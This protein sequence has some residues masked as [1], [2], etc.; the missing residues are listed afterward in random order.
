MQ[1]WTWNWKTIHSPYHIF[2]EPLKFLHNFAIASTN[3]VSRWTVFFFWLRLCAGSSSN[4]RLTKGA[5]ECEC[6][7]DYVSLIGVIRRVCFKLEHCS[8]DKAD[9]AYFSIK[10]AALQVKVEP[11]RYSAQTMCLVHRSIVTPS[12]LNPRSDHMLRKKWMMS[13][14][15]R[16]WARKRAA[17]RSKTFEGE[18]AKIVI[19]IHLYLNQNW[20]FVMHTCDVVYH[21]IGV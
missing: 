20:G 15:N 3:M 4:G 10:C 16:F 5:E 18:I 2:L 12:D 9:R 13:S 17:Q 8:V 14:T 21:C 7:C 19:F 1:A 6:D 11:V